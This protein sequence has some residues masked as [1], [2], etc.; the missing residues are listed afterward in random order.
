[1]GGR[2]VKARRGPALACLLAAVLATAIAATPT[3]AAGLGSGAFN[4]LTAGQEQA[5][6]PTTPARTTS[7]EAAT[8]STSSSNSSSLILGASVAAILLLAAIGLVIVRDA[9][10]VA[11]A[12]D[13]EMLE[14]RASHDA[15]VRLRRR[16]AKAKAARQQRKRN[17]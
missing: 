3:S 4:E 17:R 9:R 8:T 11:P 10:R 14:V 13:P 16:R 1:M 15:A 2:D 6:T 7:G 5:T 12:G